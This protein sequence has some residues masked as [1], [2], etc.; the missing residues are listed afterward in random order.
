[1]TIYLLL[2]TAGMLT[3]LLPCILPLVPIVL[4]V[5]LSGRRKSRP[6]VAVLGMVGSF[7][8]FTFLAQ[9]LLRR[10]VRAADVVGTVAVYAL[11]L[12]GI[13]FLI[14]DRRTRVGLA[15]LGAF[16]FF[17]NQGLL[18]L[19]AAPLLGAVAMLL[20]G[21]IAG[22]IQAVGADVQQGAEVGLGRESLLTTFIVGLT[23]GLVW[24]PCAGPALGFA[25]ALVRDEPGPRA[26]LALTSYSAGAATPLLLIGYGGQGI[27][28]SAR[29]LTR[30][31]GHIKQI[32][33]GL[34]VLSAFALQYQLFLRVETWLVD[35]TGFGN[36][37]TRLE[38]RLFR[39]TL[40]RPARAPK[41]LI[42]ASL[43]NLPVLPRIRPA[44]EFVGLGPWYNSP[45][46][47]LDSLLGKV[48]LVDFWT[49]SCINC[50]R[51]FPELRQLWAK[52]GDQPFV[53][54]GVH[55]PEFAF[56]KS[57]ANVAAA[58]KRDGLTYPIAQDND[59]RTWNAFGNRYW[60]AKY[61]IDAHGMIRYEHFGEGRAE[62]TDLDIRSLLAEIG[63]PTPAS[64][65]EAQ[66]SKPAHPLS[67][68]TYLSSRGWPAFAN[69]VGP[70]DGRRH[71][72]RAPGRL[73]LDT[74]ALVGDWQLVDDERQVLRSDMGEVHYRAL[75]GEVNLVLGVEANADPIV[76]EVTIDGK[77]YKQ[78]TIDRHD[79]Y[80]LF[81]GPYG[82]H[83]VTVRFR[84]PNVAAY[85][86]TFGV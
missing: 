22:R 10:V 19:V 53:I 54:V 48:V 80:N 31:G 26:L 18:A 86:F 56:E 25:L 65:A 67:P 83:W 43:V 3:I 70:P 79:L 4:G 6:L 68:E 47:T 42:A 8:L 12:F 30:Y 16:P 17:W 28:R 21:R 81:N 23:L 7:V 64:A 66:P 78:L 82:E 38:E 20:G 62:Q 75:A 34:L 2:F 41:Q 74:F 50:I 55:S 84:G 39:K 63:H 13:G 14:E 59:L 61:L 1:V 27:V 44:P 76:A 32:A 33:G 71:H 51:T 40:D 35:R 45:P 11:F 49:Y 24:V 52:Y 15:V 77:I 85:A 69:Q 36:L 58:V 5:S 37:A 46:L 29:R 60:P 73:A 72:Y 9:L 57:P